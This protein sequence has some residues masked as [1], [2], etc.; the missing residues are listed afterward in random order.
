LA[1]GGSSGFS[2]IA[3]ST[4]PFLGGLAHSLP[5]LLGGFLGGG[6]ATGEAQA[7]GNGKGQTGGEKATTH[8]EGTRHG[9]EKD[10]RPLKGT[11]FQWGR[12]FLKIY[13][14]IATKLFL[15]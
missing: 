1:S 3:D 8:E 12:T 14:S 2:G 6:G 11:G 7:A 9:E 15:E 5:C 4:S 13:A 10:E